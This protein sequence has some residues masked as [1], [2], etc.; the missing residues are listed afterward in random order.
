LLCILFFLSL[1]LFV[2]VSFRLLSSWNSLSAQTPAQ[3]KVRTSESPEQ[4]KEYSHAS[5]YGALI[6]WQRS[7][8]AYLNTDVTCLCDTRGQGSNCTKY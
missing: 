2:S 4:D 7:P 6:Q 5:Q 1:V 3:M 8:V